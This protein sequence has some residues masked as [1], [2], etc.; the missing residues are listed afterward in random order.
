MKLEQVMI[1]RPK[2]EP[3]TFD[4]EVHTCKHCDDPDACGN[5]GKYLADPQHYQIQIAY[6]AQFIDLLSK[7]EGALMMKGYHPNQVLVPL[8][9]P[10]TFHFTFRGA[11]VI[12]TGEVRTPTM[13]RS[14]TFNHG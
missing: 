2:I 14:E 4:P 12:R 6:F 10:E 7:Q 1:I 13:Q 8:C 9:A 5:T 11:E 3:K